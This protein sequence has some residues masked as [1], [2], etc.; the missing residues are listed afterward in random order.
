MPTDAVNAESI[1]TTSGVR[2]F[3]ASQQLLAIHLNSYYI[4]PFSCCHPQTVLCTW[5]VGTSSIE[6]LSLTSFLSTTPFFADLVESEI[7]SWHPLRCIPLTH[8]NDQRPLDYVAAG[9]ILCTHQRNGLGPPLGISHPQ[10]GAWL[11]LS[12]RQ[13]SLHK[14]KIH[15][16]E[17]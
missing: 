1:C 4:S 14:V 5:A 2:R 7:G 9:T 10:T 13:I 8:P 15:R 16:G 12:F 17:H 11:A 3:E 6:S